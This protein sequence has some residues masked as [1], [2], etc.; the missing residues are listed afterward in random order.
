M[1]FDK[2]DLYERASWDGAAGISRRQLLERLQGESADSDVLTTAFISPTVMVPSRRL[3][4]LLDQAR[5]FQQQTCLYHD[6]S[7]PASLYVDHECGSGQFPS[8]TTHILA[9]HTDEVWRIEWSPDGMLLASAGK[10]QQ[11]VVW[12]LKVCLPTLDLC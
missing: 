9:D 4:T 12:E 3:A 8:V 2:D 1:C 10:D 11:V 6:D 7:E 5:Q